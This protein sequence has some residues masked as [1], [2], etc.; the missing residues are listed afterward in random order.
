MMAFP[1]HGARGSRLSWR[2]FRLDWTIFLCA[3]SICLI[4]LA[5]IYSASAGDPAQL[6][7]Q[8][9]HVTLALAAMILFARVDIETYRRYS[10]LLYL[11]SVGL[12][13]FSLVGGSSDTDIR[14]WIDLGF[15]S[16]QPSELTKLTLPMF[17]CWLAV[18]RGLPVRAGTAALALICLAVPVFLVAKQPDLGTALLLTAVGLGALLVVG[19]SWRLVGGIG[20][21]S[22]LSVPLV[23]SFLHDYQKRRL[24]FFF[25]PERDPLGAGY[26]VMQSEIAIGSGGMYGKGWLNGTQSYL[27][28]LPER[29]TDFIFSVFCEE[30]GFMGFLALLAA[31]IAVILRGAFIA[32]GC[33]DMYGRTLCISLVFALF[34]CMY[35][36]MS[37]ASGQLPVVGVPLPLVSMGGTA[38]VSSAMMLGIVM[39]VARHGR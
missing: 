9:F 24:L 25:D 22:F 6:T 30:F 29:S 3:V 14:R 15:V 4:G 20:I 8:L 36:N 1:Q 32:L 27:E 2:R 26:H 21:A 31:Y 18:W 35:V 19:I 10:P 23:W 34:L 12:L 37:M 38:M 11:L 7:R 16:F 5:A 39:S 13:V 17:L 28:F 33:K